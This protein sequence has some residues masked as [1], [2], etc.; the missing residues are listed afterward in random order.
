MK[1]ITHY[2]NVQQGCQM[3]HFHT[4]NSNLGIFWMPLE[5][6]M[7]IQFMVIWYIL[8]QLSKFWSYLAYFVVILIVLVSCVKKNLAT[9]MYNSPK[10]HRIRF[11]LYIPTYV[12]RLLPKIENFGGFF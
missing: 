7:L 1:S 5:C 6:K 10:S 11:C 8:S 4:N 9:L 12:F 2:F 3:K